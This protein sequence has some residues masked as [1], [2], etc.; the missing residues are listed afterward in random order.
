MNRKEENKSAEKLHTGHRRRIKEQLLADSYGDSTPPHLLLEILLY[1]SI[2]RRD[3]NIIAHELLNHFGSI[4][5]VVF[6][7]KSELMKISGVTENTVALFRVMKLISRRVALD[8]SDKTDVVQSYNDMGKYF[9][10]KF[11]SLRTEYVAVLFLKTSGKI[12]SFDIVGEGDIASVGL[13]TRKVLELAIKYGAVNVVLCHNHPS[14][15]ALPSE[16]DVEITKGLSLS[17]RQIGVHLI[18]HIIVADNDYVSMA[19]SKEYKNIF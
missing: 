1:F 10:K 13:S 18:D 6:A 8:R 3:T 5:N 4:E 9:L 2:P 11:T 7:P 15:V 17:L 16:V 19:Q 14:G 12:I